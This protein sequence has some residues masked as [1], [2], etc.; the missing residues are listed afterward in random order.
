MEKEFNGQESLTLI[1]EMISQARNNFRK[2]TANRVIFVG[3]SVAVVAIMNLI[4]VHTLPNPNQSY[5]I[6]L[7]MIPMSIINVC[8]AKKQDKQALVKTHI[9]KIIG[10]I[11]RAYGYSIIVLLLVIFGTTAIINAAY[12][13][14]LITPIILTLTGLA[15]Y[16][17]ATACR[18]KPYFYGAAI[19]WIG[20]LLCIG[21]YCTGNGS[22]QF[23]ILA[24]AFIA[25]FAIPGQLLNRKAE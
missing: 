5:W 12:L 21:S 3:Y 14:L 8:I 22:I 19:F 11:W 9:D 6:W 25:G 2:E 24:A 1:N 13:P 18:F 15:Q 4:L 16:A 17:T 23:I 20:V 7:L 10:A